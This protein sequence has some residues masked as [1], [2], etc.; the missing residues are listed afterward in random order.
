M[1]S[2]LSPI[3]AGIY[4]CS[5]KN[6]FINNSAQKVKIKKWIRYVDGILIIWEE[7]TVDITKFMKGLNSVETS[8]Q[9]KEEI[10]M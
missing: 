1:E 7:D 5:F 8:L 2:L 6:K 4:M 3:T 9:F 10:G